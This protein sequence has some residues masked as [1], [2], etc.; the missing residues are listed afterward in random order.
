MSSRRYFATANLA[1]LSALFLIAATRA[2]NAELAGGFLGIRVTEDQSADGETDGKD[3]DKS[4]PENDTA[5]DPKEESSAVKR[6]VI[7][8]V[9]SPSPAADAGLQVGDVIVSVDG[10]QFDSLRGFATAIATRKPGETILIQLVRGNE[11]LKASAT[12]SERPKKVAEPPPSKDATSVE[13]EDRLQPNGKDFLSSEPPQKDA[14]TPEK[15]SP[16]FLGVQLVKVPEILSVHLQLEKDTGVLVAN[17]LDD[18][19]AARA[20]LRK[21]DV[22]LAIDG[23]PITDR[24]FL[25]SKLAGENIQLDLLRRGARQQVSVDLG[26]RPNELPQGP[27]AIAPVDD[28]A[29]RW[30]GRLRLPKLRGKLYFERDGKK[31]VFELPEL[32]LGRAG[33][34]FDRELAKKLAELRELPPEIDA[35][36]DALLKA[37]REEK[38][39][40]FDRLESD[41]CLMNRLQFEQDFCRQF[42]DQIR[43]FDLDWEC[44]FELKQS[45][46]SSYLLR[47]GDDQHVVTVTRE[48]GVDEI[49]VEDRKGTVIFD[50]ISRKDVAKLPEEIRKKVEGVLGKVDRL[51]PQIEKSAPPLKNSDAGKKTKSRSIKL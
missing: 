21:D 47:S 51:C 39:Q 9:L 28:E 12:L 15:K 46:R 18:S 29:A 25:Q 31:Q 49:T 30:L 4:D 45:G 34:E 16:G 44:P 24:R 1:L 10:K 41:D 22:L 27:A 32:D 37:L 43:R 8:R 35:R 11:A 26:S 3:A 6:F 7:E 13:P 33:E 17:V 48:N 5:K 40:L 42:Q 50:K 19:P 2:A 36:V 14:T 20:G 38:E 23:T